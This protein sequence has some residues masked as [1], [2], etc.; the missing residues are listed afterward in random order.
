MKRGQSVTFRQLETAYLSVQRELDR[1]GLWDGRTRL[2]KT[3]VIWCWLPPPGVW[4]AL[5]FFVDEDSLLFR[6]FGYEPGD[7]YVPKWVLLHGPWQN[8]GSLRDVLR[9]EF[10]H[11]LAFYHPGPTRRCRAFREA[12]AARYDE[13]WSEPPGDRKDFVSAYAMTG[14]AEDFAE[15]FACWLRTFASRGDSP[16]NSA[17]A[18][19]FTPA[20]RA[21]FAFIRDVCRRIGG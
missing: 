11:A 15:T 9:H 10:G 8:R 20:L 18:R 4:D 2:M 7:I 3:E 5:G 19:R 14:P 16:R 21:K 17:A 13:C 12:F 1:A 6:L